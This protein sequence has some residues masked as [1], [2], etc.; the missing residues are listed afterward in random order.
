M[1]VG[2][3]RDVQAAPPQPP[4]PQIVLGHSPHPVFCRLKTFKHLSVRN[5]SEDLDDLSGDPSTFE[6]QLE[7]LNLGFSQHDLDRAA[8]ELSEAYLPPSRFW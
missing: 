7:S 1:G 2:A 8:W 4:P 3:P 6:F 5:I